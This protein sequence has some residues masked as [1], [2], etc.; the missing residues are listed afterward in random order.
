MNWHGNMLYRYT[1]FTAHILLR[2]LFHLQVTGRKNLRKVR[3]AVIAVNHSSFADPVFAGV[4]CTRPIYY[5]ARKDLFNNRLFGWFLRAINVL[6]FNRDAPDTITLK[7]AIRLLQGG[8]MVLIFPEGTR[9]YDGN[10]M[11]PHPGIGFIALKAGAPIIPMY[12]D[13]AHKIL[14]RGAGFIRLAKGR[15]RI[16]EPIYLDTWLRKDRIERSDYEEVADLVMQRLRKL[17]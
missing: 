2:G 9:S 11:T 13:G 17:S 7:K 12:I 1:R 16:G 15:V 4:A 10:L 14:P 8:K 3:G 5:I 6:P